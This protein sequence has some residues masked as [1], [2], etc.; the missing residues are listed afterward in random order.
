MMDFEKKVRDS[1]SELADRWNMKIAMVDRDD[2]VIVGADFALR[3]F[4][5]RDGV[6]LSY[7]D[8]SPGGFREYELGHFLATRRIW[9]GA[10][11]EE[12]RI[13]RELLAFSAT[14]ESSAKDVLGGDKSW[15]NAFA[16][17]DLV[18]DD[19]LS[20]VLKLMW[21]RNSLD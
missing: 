5:D 19:E 20:L 8:G 6:N 21:S 7:V 2:A 9:I 17:G 18:L 10:P 14:L 15:M 4:L 16:K 12:D 3:L 11:A 13:V 1:F